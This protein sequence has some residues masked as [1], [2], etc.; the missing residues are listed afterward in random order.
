MVFG[1]ETRPAYDRIHLTDMLGGRTAQS[2][3][4]DGFAW[5]ERRGIEL[6]AEFYEWLARR[7]LG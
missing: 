4:L 7:M 3:E 6:A 1:E 2:L 5:Y